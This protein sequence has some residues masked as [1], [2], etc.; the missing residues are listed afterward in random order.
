MTRMTPPQVASDASP[1]PTA[2]GRLAGIMK[3]YSVLLTTMLVGHAYLWAAVQACTV[4]EDA[5]AGCPTSHYASK[6]ATS[7]DGVGSIITAV[8]NL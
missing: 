1:I 7:C 5:C 6:T 3:V 2:A 4:S 8:C